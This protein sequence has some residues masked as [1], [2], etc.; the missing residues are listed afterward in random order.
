MALK[1]SQPRRSASLKSERPILRTTNAVE[2][3][4]NCSLGLA[5]YCVAMAAVSLARG[6]RGENGALKSRVSAPC[7][8]IAVEP[9]TANNFNE[10]ELR[11][12]DPA[13]TF[14]VSVA[15]Y[16]IEGNSHHGWVNCA[17]AHRLLRCGTKRLVAAD[18]RRLAGLGITRAGAGRGILL[19]RAIEIEL[20]TPG[21]AGTILKI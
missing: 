13:A 7:A 12:T 8:K 21:V 15:R 3:P 6:R 2:T 9:S 10:K 19:Y 17:S 5:K 20:L 1:S 14:A 4:N 18:A 11:G 16:A